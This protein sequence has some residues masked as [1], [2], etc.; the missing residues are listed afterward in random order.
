[1]VESARDYSFEDRS[2]TDPVV[3]VSFDDRGPVACDPWS[4]TAGHDSKMSA[5][6]SQHLFLIGV[7]CSG[8]AFRGPG[9][10]LIYARGA[11]A[12]SLSG[13]KVEPV[14]RVHRAG[15]FWMLTE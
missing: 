7:G 8:I 3:R 14:I 5:G 13:S 15:I 4:K 1:M 10:A 9:Q 6:S 12:A 11:I 2:H